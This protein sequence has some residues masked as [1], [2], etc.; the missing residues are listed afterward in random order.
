MS[1]DLLVITRFR[2]LERNELPAAPRDWLW[3]KAVHHSGWE[4]RCNV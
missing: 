3:S 1:K 2:S 4:T